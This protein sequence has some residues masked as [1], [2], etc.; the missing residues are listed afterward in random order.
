[1]K[2]VFLVVFWL[3][4]WPVFSQSLFEQSVDCIKRYEGLHGRE[5]HPYVGYGHRLMPGEHFDAGM[6][7]YSA[8]SLLRV[9]LLRRCA[10]FREFGR[11]SLLLAVLAYNIGETRVRNS[12]LVKKLRSGDRD[13]SSEYLSFR[14][15]R[16]KVSPV[17]ERRRREEYHLL[18][19]D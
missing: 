2:A 19:N 17:L 9:D 12:R 4:S 10:L 13:I 5:H 11:D 18:Y 1:M 8:D 16:G 3:V 7:E 15:I 14:L 6:N